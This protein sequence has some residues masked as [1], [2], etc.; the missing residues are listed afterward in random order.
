MPLTYLASFK[1]SRIYGRKAT[2]TALTSA[3]S[4]GANTDPTAT[5]LFSADPNRTY[6]QARN[7]HSSDAMFYGYAVLG[8]PPTVAFLLSEGQELKA[9]E[10]T[11]DLEDPEAIYAISATGNVIPCRC[12]KGTG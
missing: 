5:L 3:V 11:N 9:G 6:A 2:T 4:V 10:V 8:V 12:D 1:N 7:L